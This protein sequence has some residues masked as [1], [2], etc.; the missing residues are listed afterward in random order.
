MTSGRQRVQDHRI[1]QCRVRPTRNTYGEENQLI[2]A[3]SRVPRETKVAKEEKEWGTLF[4]AENKPTPQM[5]QFVAITV[6]C[7][8]E[9]TAD[10]M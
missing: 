2:E 1:Q 10:Y 4:P 3:L 6:L 5:Q 8:P 9:L 7:E